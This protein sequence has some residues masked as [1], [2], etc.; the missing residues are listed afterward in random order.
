MTQRLRLVPPAVP[1][2]LVSVLVALATFA[3]LAGGRKVDLVVAVPDYAAYGVRSVAVLPVA[4]FDRNVQAERLVGDR[5]NPVLREAGY[6]WFSA[7]TTR[8]LVRSAF[9]DST[10]KVMREE[11]LKNVRVDSLRAPQLCA[12]L[13]TDA[14]LCVRVEQWEQR[15]IE[16]NQ[17]GRPATTVQL[18]AALVDSTGT[19]LWSI[20]G[21]ETS[22]G[23]YHDP[24]SNP[25]GVHG[26]T[27]EN[28]PITGQGGPPG[29][30]D[31]LNQLVARWTP[32]FPH[33]TAAAATSP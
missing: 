2:L 27:L 1:A 19:L 24:S 7:A 31:V 18:K 25:L 5:W 13:H 9:G 33:A 22:E 16:W 21:S 28:T 10:A 17:P 3:A 26:S 29:Y 15:Q 6:R 11:I 23:P 4:T 8:D 32:L 30:E 12:R 20:S 14:V